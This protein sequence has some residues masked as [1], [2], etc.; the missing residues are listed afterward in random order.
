MGEQLPE[1]IL[2]RS[3][4]LPGDEIWVTGTLGDAAMGLKLLEDGFDSAQPPGSGF[5]SAHPT[6]QLQGRS[7][8]GVEGLISRLLDPTP[9]TAA[10]LALAGSG[11][12][13][14][15]IDISDGILADFGHIAEMS[16]VGGILQ[17]NQV[18]VSEAFREQART[19][20]AF[21]CHLTLS[22][23][24]DYELAFTASPDNREKIAHVLKKC[25]VAAMPV[26][27]VTN[28]PEVV[29]LDA[30]GR[31]YHIENQGFNHFA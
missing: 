29:V 6:T 18:P 11:L 5:G 1:R 13:T 17:L 25:G 28:S 10:G 26:G 15:M 16:G 22:G 30:A 3:G 8:S 21:P 14:A 9:R 20:P 23:G 2:R 24:E 19:F 4:A 12:V 7:L 31:N 27:I